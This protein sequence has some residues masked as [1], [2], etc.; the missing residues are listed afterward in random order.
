MRYPCDFGGL[1]KY[2]GHT[3]QQSLA[4]ASPN[5]YLLIDGSALPGTELYHDILRAANDPAVVLTGVGGTPLAS[6]LKTKLIK[7][8]L[9]SK[10]CNEWFQKWCRLLPTIDSSEG[11]KAHLK[12]PKP[13]SDI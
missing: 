12:S 4:L 10:I 13:S 7:M 2:S 5:L 8:A 3:S 1:V 9:T 11:R 6:V